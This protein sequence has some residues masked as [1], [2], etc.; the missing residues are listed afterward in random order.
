MKTSELRVFDSAEYLNSEEA[1]AAYLEACA[2]IG[3]PSEIANALG[4]V[5]RARGMTQL[6]RDTGVARES[7]YKALRPEGNPS[8][9]TLA[10]IVDAFG[11]RLAFVPKGRRKEGIAPRKGRTGSK[12]KAETLNAGDPMAV[13]DIGRAGDDKPVRMN[14]ARAAKPKSAKTGLP[15]AR[16]AA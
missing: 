14:R 8:L 2:E 1:V 16:R 9:D 13:D 10:R 12:A 15:R 3:D 4:V 7:L 5:A 11:L 6:A